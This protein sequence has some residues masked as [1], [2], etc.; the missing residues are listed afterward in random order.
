M[1][2]IF[3]VLPSVLLLLASALAAPSA[4]PEE[5]IN[6]STCTLG[7]DSRDLEIVA[8]G[9][10]HVV[11]YT[12]NGKTKEVGTCSANKQKCQEIFDEIQTNL[13]KAGYHCKV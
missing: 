10:G 13:K 2:T 3:I 8:R 9:E 6:K 11:T 12:K 7:P 4:V 1:K 5:M